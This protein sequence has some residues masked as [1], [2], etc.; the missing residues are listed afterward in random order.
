MLRVFYLRFFHRIFSSPPKKGLQNIEEHYHIIGDHC[1]YHPCMLHFTFGHVGL[2]L[3]ANLGKYNIHRWY[4]LAARLIVAK[5]GPAAP[6]TSCRD[7]ICTS[8]FPP[9]LP[10]ASQ[11]WG[12]ERP[13]NHG[14][15]GMVTF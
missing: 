1:P 15:D 12:G 13:P 2:I 14:G 7:R 11:V 5:S 9:P 6:H 4:G 10:P 3:A 8:I